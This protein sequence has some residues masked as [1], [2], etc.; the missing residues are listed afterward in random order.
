MDQLLALLDQILASPT[1]TA[2]LTFVL[3]AVAAKYPWLSSLLAF[4]RRV[5]PAPPA[6]NQPQPAVPDV[7]PNHP[8]LNAALQALLARLLEK[9][10]ET[11]PAVAV[12]RELEEKKQP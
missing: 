9:H 5:V 4:F 7:V 8:L 10:K 6:P 11:N 3:T 2:I 12:L 1:A